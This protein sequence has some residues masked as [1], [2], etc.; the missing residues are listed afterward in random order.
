MAFGVAYAPWLTANDLMESLQVQPAGATAPTPSATSLATGTPTGD[1]SF[2]I[3]LGR[4]LASTPDSVQEGP[5][6]G[7][8]ASPAPLRGKGT[9]RDNSDSASMAGIVLNCFV[10]NLVQP[11]PTVT[12]SGDAGEP[13]LSLPSPGAEA[14]AVPAPSCAPSLSV[15]AGEASTITS[16]SVGMSTG[17]LSPSVGVAGIAALST[18][19]AWTGKDVRL[20]GTAK[21]AASRSTMRGEVSTQ[22]NNF[23][24]KTGQNQSD[25]SAA[26]QPV[27]TP[28]WFPGLQNASP[29]GQPVEP[30]VGVAQPESKVVVVQPGSKQA[31]TSSPG[32]A[33]EARPRQ[34]SQTSPD[35]TSA[36][37]QRGQFEQAQAA[38]GPG[39]EA[40][41][42]SAPLFPIDH[43]ERAAYS[44][45]PVKSAGADWQAASNPMPSSV[46]TEPSAPVT[47]PHASDS[48]TPFSATDYP[49]VPEY[50]SPL[51]NSTGADLQGSNPSLSISRVGQGPPRSAVEQHGSPMP[52]S[53]ID[54]SERAN[55]STLLG[56]FSGTEISVKVSGDESQQA[57]APVESATISTPV[58]AETLNSGP[59]T[60]AADAVQVPAAPR[61]EDLVTHVAKGAIHSTPVS[62][63]VMTEAAWQKGN[64]LES[65]SANL[66][67][68]PSAG[69]GLPVSSWA[70]ANPPLSSPA[71][72]AAAP[73]V[74]TKSRPAA[75]AAIL[76]KDAAP[77]ANGVQL[78]GEASSDSGGC[79][80]HT[81]LADSS[82]GG[83][84]GQQNG[85]T[86]R[87]NPASVNTIAPGLPNNPATD[88]TASL[89]ATHAPNPPASPA[90]VS[91][92][93]APPSSGQAPATLSAWQNYDGGAGS[94][95]RS[96]SLTGSAN[97]A[98]MHVEFRTGALGPMEVHAV[99]SGGS[100]GAE[101]HVQG[102][103]A[104]TLLAAGVPALERALGERNLRVEN[105]AVYQ[106]HA[107]GGTSGGEKQDQQS[108]SNPSAQHQVL[109]WG[110]PPQSSAAA[111]GSLDG[112][113]LANPAVGLSV[114]A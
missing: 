12:P 70:S 75:P 21:L 72:P 51:G 56:R 110:N 108:G 17:T 48:P 62:G 2:A 60:V 19:P 14:T 3:T 114:R 40:V 104:H 94:I 112:E 79:A 67:H 106:D 22:S 20:L 36:W 13:T 15:S 38:P 107:G 98:E 99:V 113:E 9:T 1:D 31:G 86:S 42:S 46:P 18:F 34:E 29:L 63:S 7:P 10:T 65:A 84:S 109:L 64:E 27:S 80:A 39:S 92:P 74:D 76:P 71:I 95:V 57:T 28:A 49:E 4:A 55:I 54:S 50:S 24:L 47:G 81:T 102:Q 30:P 105:I 90:H 111:G 43:P 103:E 88:S 53:A 101:I 11:P 37:P 78:I 52:A 82:T 97:G 87:D 96:A 59:R 93:P 58:A 73:Q 16:T 91:A 69:V 5:S 44:T 23:V 45:L 83:K 100:V 85:Q 61:G 8:K 68:S 35:L 33:Q 89:L 41:E 77:E 26:I 66:P 25:D 32:S 6:I